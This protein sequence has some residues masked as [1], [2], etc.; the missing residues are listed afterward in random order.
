M[1]KDGRLKTRTGVYL[2]ATA[3]QCLCTFIALKP[4]RAA[5]KKDRHSILSESKSDHSVLKDQTAA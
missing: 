4:I 3:R 2:A 5:K 1:A